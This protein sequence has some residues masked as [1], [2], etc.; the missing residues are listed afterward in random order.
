MLPLPA[1]SA[2]WAPDAGSGARQRE[3]KPEPFD[4]QGQEPSDRGGLDAGQLPHAI[5]EVTH[6]LHPGHVRVAGGRD[7]E[8]RNVDAS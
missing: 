6:E 5:D 8:R 2:D 7:V 1:T 4:R 3:P